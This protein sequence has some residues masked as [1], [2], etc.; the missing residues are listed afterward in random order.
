[1]NS[2][3]KH[4]T[5]VVDHPPSS[6]PP[7]KVG[8]FLRNLFRKDK[9]DQE[10]SDDD[11]EEH[12]PS[13]DKT[14]HRK[15]AKDINNNNSNKTG[16]SPST[17][18]GNKSNTKQKNNPH[19]GP[20]PPKNNVKMQPKPKKKKPLVHDDKPM[21]IPIPKA[22]TNADPDHW[23][24]RTLSLDGTIRY[25]TSGRKEE[26]VGGKM[27][28]EEACEYFK[29]NPQKYTALT[30][31][32]SLTRAPEHKQKFT[33]VHREGTFRYRPCGVRQDKKGWMTMLLYEYRPLPVLEGNI[34]P[35]KFRDRYTDAMT[36]QGIKLHNS[37]NLPVLPG[38]GMGYC[39]SPNIKL[40]GD[41]DPNDIN[42]G[43]VG[44]CWLLGAIS[45]LAEFDG[46][47]KRMFRKTKLLDQRPLKGPNMY[48]VTLWDLPTW[49]QVDIEIDERL[50]VMAD[51]S[52]KLLSAK[53]SADGEL[54]VS[55]LEKAIAA[56]CG[57]WDKITGGKYNNAGGCCYHRSVCHYSGSSIA[58]FCHCP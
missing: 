48:T 16:A 42:Q 28:I 55:Y 44:D 52:G 45:S 12:A 50:P 9:G 22:F 36:H 21:K 38:R 29:E 17:K 18:S 56:H 49:T 30:Y 7:N 37:K 5:A 32:D 39:D 47:I 13:V 43:T 54:W 24:F 14:S 53:P 20:P 51:G 35:E 6:P 40:I 8:G 23:T 58:L 57:G 15:N 11:G 26:I 34:L 1:M 4:N 3:K 25:E 10:D 19:S 31:Q 27:T 33:L 2:N 46:A 41:V